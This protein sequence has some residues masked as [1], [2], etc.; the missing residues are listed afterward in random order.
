MND[1]SLPPFEPAQLPEHFA[2]R[3]PVATRTYEPA[4]IVHRGGYHFPPELERRLVAYLRGKG[5]TVEPPAPAAPIQPVEFVATSG[6]LTR[7]MEKQGVGW[8]D[9]WNYFA[10]HGYNVDHLPAYGE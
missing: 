5:W 6:D 10:E 8:S 3:P 7:H 9:A 4:G 2:P 1:R